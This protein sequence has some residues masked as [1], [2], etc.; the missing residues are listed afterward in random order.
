MHE[1]PSLPR[2]RV[3]LTA[4][5]AWRAPVAAALQVAGIA[6]HPDAAL[7]L[8]VGPAR[9]VLPDVD[10]WVV[11]SAPHLLL[12]VW[13]HGTEVGPWVLPGTGPC[14]R[15]VAAGTLDDTG[16]ALPP[17]FTL[18]A[19]RLDRP[20]LALAAGWVAR[21]LLR[22]LR[23]ETPLTW[24][25][26]WFLGDDAVPEPRSWHRHPYCGCAWWETA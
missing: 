11:E 4:P 14:A 19:T 26:S 16:R 22:W 25:T 5:A 9:T 23:G 21:D 6:T 20:G 2:A 18:D 13:P 7:G 24:G 10:D 3:R 1:T 17:G 8:A 15:C 12:A